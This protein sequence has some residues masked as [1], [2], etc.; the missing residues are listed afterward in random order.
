M[1]QLY[2]DGVLIYDPYLEG[3]EL[4]KLTAT[5]DVAKAGTATITM[6]AGHPAYDSFVHLRTL[7][8]IYRDDELIFRGRAL[9][10]ADNFRRERT[11]TCAGER[12]FLN[13]SVVQPYL[14]QADPAVIFSDLIRQHNSQV[15]PFKQF[16]VG[17]ITAKDPNGY[18]RMESE[19]AAKTASVIDT[20]VERVG[21]YVTFSTDSSG[22]R[23]INWL[24]S[25]DTVSRQGIEFG[26]NLMDYASN[27]AN[28][29]LATIIYPYGAKDEKTGKRLTIANVNGGR[30]YIQDDEA[31]A[32]HGRIADT[33]TFD[34]V[35]IASNLLKKARQ[36]LNIRKLPVRSLELTALDLS[37]LNRNIDAFRVGEKVPVLSL[38]HGLDDL[39][40]LCRRD[41][42]FLTESADRVVMGKELTTLTGSTAGSV[43]ALTAQVN[44]PGK[45]V[46]NVYNIYS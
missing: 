33:V 9:Y 37:R 15:D 39:F 27:G 16:R 29:D 8:E 4:L 24:A 5:V 41:Y 19:S 28:T 38:P 12:D 1:A 46:T 40:L 3:H 32:R 11:I 13:D 18:I 31:I 43:K 44:K 7:V 2:A 26:E 17:A 23:T 30:L 42:D 20:L 14:Y 45:G 22:R 21:G 34:D 10:P 36:A 25:L 6:P 35:T